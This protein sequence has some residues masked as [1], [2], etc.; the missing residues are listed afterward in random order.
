MRGADA[1][2]NAFEQMALKAEEWGLD[3]LWCS[4]HIIIPELKTSKYPG[5]GSGEF[6]PNWLEGYWE[7]FTVLGYVAAITKK[8][9]LGTSVLIMPMRNPIEV[10]RNVADLDQLAEGRFI[11]GVGVG[12]FREEFDA[13]DWPFN[14]RGARTNEGLDLCK[15]LWTE[16]RPSYAGK[17]YNFEN[18]YF[19]PKPVSKPHPPIW[20]GGKSEAAYKRVARFADAWHPNRPTFDGLAKDLADLKVHMDAAGRKM[21]HLTIGVKSM[22][23]FQDGPPGEGQMPTEG[24]PEMIISAIKRYQEMGATHFT[25]DFTP[26]TLD[27]ALYTMERFVNEIRPKL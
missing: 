22:L 3:S 11:L 14:Q 9:A 6:P 26:E 13:L 18:V 7:P 27:N 17:F 23:T 4:D 24:T 20:V 2:R 21:E 19:A 12:W 25:F 16:E 5:R 1:T 8:I 10:A 15:T